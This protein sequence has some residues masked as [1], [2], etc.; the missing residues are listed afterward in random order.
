VL[1]AAAVGRRVLICECSRKLL[2]ITN[3]QATA[4]L[5]LNPLSRQS[6][7]LRFP[8]PHAQTAP[9]KP[10]PPILRCPPQV[11]TLPPGIAGYGTQIPRLR[12]G[13]NTT[14]PT[15]LT[16]TSCLKLSPRKQT[17]PSRRNGAL[18]HHDYEYTAVLAQ[19][20]GNSLGLSK[21]CLDA[22]APPYIAPD[23]KAGDKKPQVR[24][25]RGQPTHS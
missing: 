3:C 12:I 4:R 2:S 23:S 15:A 13:A 14:C 25:S 16:T 24:P 5:H 19:C 17:C 21:S 18:N 6:A 10:P 9:K 8:A 22:L 20:A 11:P 1:Q 7:L